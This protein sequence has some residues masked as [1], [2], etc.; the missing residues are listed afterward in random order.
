MFFILYESLSLFKTTK[1][2]EIS[3]LLKNFLRSKT[4]QDKTRRGIFI[5][6][7]LKLNNFNSVCAAPPV[8]VS[9]AR[10]AALSSLTEKNLQS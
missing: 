4:R 5:A 9:R 7:E 6:S 8:S 3:E 10:P 2:D 1:L